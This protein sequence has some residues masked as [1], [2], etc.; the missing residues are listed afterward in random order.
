[1]E[2]PMEMISCKDTMYI[3]DILMMQYTF[4]KKLLFY[5]EIVTDTKIKDLLNK[6]SKQLTKGYDAL[7]EVLNG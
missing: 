7:L 4:I 5:D 6:V 1:M 3:S 2:E